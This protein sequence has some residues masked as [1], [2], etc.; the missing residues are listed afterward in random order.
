MNNRIQFK[1]YLDKTLDA[2]FRALI[3]DKYQKYE[4]GLLSY[5]VEMALRHWLSLHTE[6]QSQLLRK[7]PNPS[8]KIALI[9]SEVKNYLLSKFYFELKPGQQVPTVQLREAIM[10]VRGNDDRTINKWMRS[11]HKMG[12]IKPV[13]SATWEI[14]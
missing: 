5:E 2:K 14:L 6:A 8:P 12:L 13:T 1:V 9:F 4:K 3:Q 10:N 11:F 7:P